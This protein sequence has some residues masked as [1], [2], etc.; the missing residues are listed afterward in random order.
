MVTLPKILFLS[1]A[2]ALAGSAHAAF[3]CTPTGGDECKLQL[4]H[5]TLMFDSG[6]NNYVVDSYL[7]GEDGYV[8]A[9]YDFPDLTP[10]DDAGGTRA[11][12]TFSPYVYGTVGGS[13]ID[14]H[15]EAWAALEFRDL[16]FEADE[17]WRVKWVEFTVEGTRG[18]VGN[19][20]VMLSTP[21]NRVFNGDSF[22]ARG[23]FAPDTSL[24]QAVFSATARYREGPNGTAKEYGTAYA[25]FDKVSLVAHV[26]AV[27]EPATVLMWL[28]GLAAVASL[29]RVQSRAG[30]STRPC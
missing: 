10:I 17:G 27:P 22:V 26:Q 30:A 1:V 4:S 14:G 20:R 8:Y 13:G 12:F 18:R 25:S 21:G 9:P 19:G 3:N 5:V 16:R 6:V 29:A 2:V 15:H 23:R 7:S 24:Y 11:G 28:G